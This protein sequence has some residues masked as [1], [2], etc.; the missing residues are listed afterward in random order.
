MGICPGGLG[1]PRPWAEG[2]MALALL[3]QGR[4]IR[5]YQVV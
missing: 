5:P 1:Q 3:G 4:E 2:T